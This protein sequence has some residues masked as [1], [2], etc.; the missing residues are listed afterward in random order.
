MSD[1][2]VTAVLGATL[3]L[4]YKTMIHVYFTATDAS[5]IVGAEAVAGADNLYVLKVAVVAKDLGK[6]QTITIGGYTLTY[7]AYSY[8]EATVDNADA[9]LYN[10]LQALYDYSENAKAYL[11]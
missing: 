8:I 6:A 2:N 11:G 4:E 9:V 7:S 5:A 3:A 1:G 10:V